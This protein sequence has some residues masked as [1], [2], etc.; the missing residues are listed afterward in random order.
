MATISFNPD[1][2]KVN[3]FVPGNGNLNTVSIQAESSF[4]IKNTIVKVKGADTSKYNLIAVYKDS[5]I[6]PKVS[7][8]LQSSTNFTA[9]Y[10]VEFQEPGTIQLTAIDSSY[11]N[12]Y[13]TQQSLSSSTYSYSKSIYVTSTIPSAGSNSSSLNKSVS[14]KAD[15]YI[16]AVKNLGGTS[17]PPN[18]LYANPIKDKQQSASEQKNASTLQLYKEAEKI[19]NVAAA[20]SILTKDKHLDNDYQAVLTWLKSLPEQTKHEQSIANVKKY[21]TL[22]DNSNASWSNWQQDRINVPGSGT[23]TL[24]STLLTSRSFCSHLF[25]K[26]DFFIESPLIFNSCENFTVQSSSFTSISDIQRSHSFCKWDIAEQLYTLRASTKID[27]CSTS[28]YQY[29]GN[30]YTVCD[31]DVFLSSKS[32]KEQIEGSTE[33]ITNTL[34]TFC[35]NDYTLRA[36]KIVYT[37]SKQKLYSLAGSDAYYVSEG[38]HHISSKGITNIV[39]GGTTYI[40]SYSDINISSTSTLNINGGVVRIGMGAANKAVYDLDTLE[41]KNVNTASALGL[42]QPGKSASN[43]TDSKS[44][45]V[46]SDPNIDSSTVPNSQSPK[47]TDSVQ[48]AGAQQ[49]VNQAS[50]N[51]SSN[52]TT[53]RNLYQRIALGVARNPLN[54][55]EVIT[56]ELTAQGQK[57]GQNLLNDIGKTVNSWFQPNKTPPT[58]ASSQPQPSPTPTPP[59]TQPNSDVAEI[60]PSGKYYG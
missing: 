43:I 20:V 16:E 6:K 14:N 36:D 28:L 55:Q 22:L 53:Q 27:Y 31:K 24:Q 5:A 42:N 47:P 35:S 40:S 49:T 12:S 48:T 18:P 3:I 45:A 34:N 4:C 57:L 30:Q 10:K 41:Y 56:K 59:P 44:A 25:A 23:Y 17:Y 33:L 9:V 1:L 54:A 2:N 32:K 8:N 19:L 51:S 52:N 38:E 60:P 58:K 26:R 37:K 7:I 46:S 13:I 29:L 15:S 39:S 21:K 50:T 11:S